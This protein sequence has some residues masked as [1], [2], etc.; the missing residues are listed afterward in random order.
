MD[1]AEWAR[2]RRAEMSHP[3]HR[4]VAMDTRHRI[5]RTLGLAIACLTLA[6]CAGAAPQV[7]NLIVLDWAG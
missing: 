6:A 3:I 2:G 1:A 7:D 4:G 5:S